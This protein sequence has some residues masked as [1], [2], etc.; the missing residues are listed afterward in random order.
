MHDTSCSAD[1][2]P[3]ITMRLIRSPAHRRP[4]I[5]APSSQPRHR[6]NGTVRAVRILASEAAAAVGGRLIGP[7]VEF[8][9]VSF[10]SRSIEPG[11]LFVPIVAERDGHEFIG[12][13]RASGAVVHMTSEPDEFRRD[14]TAIEVADTCDRADGAGAVGTAPASRHRR[15][16][17]RQ[18]RQDVDQGSHRRGVRV[19]RCAPRPTSSSF[20]NEQGLPVTILNA[21]DDTEV[22]VLEMGMRGFGEISRAVRGGPT[23]HRR[24]DHRRRIPTPNV[25]GASTAWRSRRASWCERLPTIGHGG[26]QRRRRPGR[27]DGGEHGSVGA[28]V[29]PTRRCAHRDLELDELARP[30]VHGRHSRGGARRVDLAVSGAHMASNAAA[31]IAVAGVVGVPLEGAVDVARSRPP[32]RRCG[33]RSPRWRRGR[34]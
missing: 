7:D 23:R 11:Q 1:W 10:D 2:P 6:S 13:A 33:W 21:P 16:R 29:R 19:A 20:N 17:H 32:C 8:D 31:A 27:G 28:H 9:G 24:G 14:G 3:K 25:S 12:Q 4:V 5:A 34:R 18:R 15:R 26:A 30:A 22:L